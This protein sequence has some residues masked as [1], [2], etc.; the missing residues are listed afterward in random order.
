MPAYGKKSEPPLKAIKEM[1]SKQAEHSSK[2]SLHRGMRHPKA[3]D[4]PAR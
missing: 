3:K 2:D 4:K 1:V